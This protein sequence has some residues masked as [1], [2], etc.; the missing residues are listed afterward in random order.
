M[1]IEKDFMTDKLAKFISDVLND[2]H[3][4]EFNVGEL[5]IIK[6]YFNFVIDKRINF[7]D[8]DFWKT[9]ETDDYWKEGKGGTGLL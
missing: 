4:N 8:E 2:L 6:G 9:I 3:F 5:M 7:L 1:T